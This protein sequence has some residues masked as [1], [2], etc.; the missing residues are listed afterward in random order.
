MAL[1]ENEKKKG[2]KNKMTKRV[3]WNCDFCGKAGLSIASNGIIYCRFCVRTYHQN[4]YDLAMKILK[5]KEQKEKE[6]GK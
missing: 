3:T 1:L 6:Q 2:E 5:E 4:L